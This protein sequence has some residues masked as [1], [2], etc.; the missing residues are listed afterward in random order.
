MFFAPALFICFMAIMIMKRGRSIMRRENHRG[1]ILTAFPKCLVRYFYAGKTNTNTSNAIGSTI[2]QRITL[3]A[4]CV[5]FRRCCRG[6]VQF[7]V[8]LYT[9]RHPQRGTNTHRSLFQNAILYF[10]TQKTPNSIMKSHNEL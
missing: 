2:F 8:V 5:Q 4:S 9:N 7:D 3:T 10:C 6:L 1:C